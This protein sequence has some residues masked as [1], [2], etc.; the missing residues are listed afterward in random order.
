ML[1]DTNTPSGNKS[2]ILAFDSRS[3]YV[4]TLSSR[5]A[6]YTELHHLLAG[7]EDVSTSAE[8]R[9]KIVT[10]NC[11]GKPSASAR[12]KMWEELKK[13]YLLEPAHPLFAAFWKEWC[14][15][16]SDAEKG[17]TAFVFLAL[18]NR[19][20]TDVSLE[21][22][23]PRL[24][25]APSELRIQEVRMFID[26]SEDSHPEV[27]GWSDETRKR[28]AQHY[29]A[30]IRDFGLAQG[31]LKKTS[32]RPALFGAPTRLLIRAFHL[33]RVP[34]N[35]IIRSP[36]FRLLGIETFEIVDALTEL[37]RQ[38]ELRFK[39]QADVIELDLRRDADEPHV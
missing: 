17:L 22:L 18:N 26:K 19:F 16:L 4:S 6:L 28:V 5:S 11:L 33:A 15:S 20:V 25:R 39:M 9:A 3:K 12:N 29:M 14:L 10:E 13:R 32:I 27:A 1:T 21:W 35:E 2:L 37:N 36:F 38:G 34:D 7:V 31:V 24:R 8:L 30:S 23:F